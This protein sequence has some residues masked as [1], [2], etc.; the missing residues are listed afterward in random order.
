MSE[1][2]ARHGPDP[3]LCRKIRPVAPAVRICSTELKPPRS[4]GDPDQNQDLRDAASR[5]C[6][7]ANPRQLKASAKAPLRIRQVCCAV[8]PRLIP[9]TCGRDLA[10]ATR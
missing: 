6:E 9:K 7:S 8:E 1:F 4:A 10:S 3:A 2:Q 5:D